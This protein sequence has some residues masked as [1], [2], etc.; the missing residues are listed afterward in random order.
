VRSG[1]K[2][3]WLRDP[4]VLVAA[5][6]VLLP[7]LTAA[8]SALRHPWIPTSDWA[9]IESEVRAV[10]T[11]D[12]PLVGAFSRFGW[13]H[14]GPLPFYALALPYRLVPSDRGLLFAAAVVNIVAVVAYIC[15]VA[16]QPRVR[17]LLALA[18]LAVL[19]RGI[20]VAD[21]GDPWNPTLPLI[22]FALYL[23]LCLEVATGERRWPLP[24]LVFV[25]AFCVQ[26]HLA[27]TY[28]VLFMGGAAFG[29]RIW[30]VL[31]DHYAE[32]GW[33]LFLRERWRAMALCLGVGLVAW[34]PP[35]LDQVNGDGNLGKLFAFSRG[36]DT[37]AGY[38]ATIDERLAIGWTPQYGAWLLE[39]FGLWM[40]EAEP[41]NSF[42]SQIL[43]PGD[44]PVLL[45]VPVALGIAL[46]VVWRGRLDP[47]DRRA[48]T[49]AVVV[50]A[51]GVLAV[52]AALPGLRGSPV[53]WA[54]RW[55]VV[56]VMA[57]WLALLWAVASVAP[58]FVPARSKEPGRERMVAVAGTAAL[59]GAIAY[60]VVRAV[61][62]GSTGGQPMHESSAALLEIRS[63][64]ER[65]GREDAPVV[66]FATF[67]YTPEGLA[68]PVLLDRAGIAWID[69]RD[70][71][72][73]GRARLEV[74][75]S[76][77]LER[78]GLAADL[79]AGRVDLVARSEKVDERGLQ[80][81][82]LRYPP[83]GGD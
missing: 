21:L 70:P 39:P 57:V 47:A 81:I 14:P 1:G 4:F 67:F 64:V 24:T 80:L 25:G 66:V 69:G 26:A 83:A 12:T 8:I 42:G 71:E 31:H 59:V 77:S 48:V 18:G 72:A 58:R 43:V 82:L 74:L 16:R 10:G 3:P 68:V 29:L 37:S 52:F 56:V 32:G 2:W 35:L 40:G 75:T 46:L 63:A 20:G 13:R 11:R 55:A 33:R 9:H 53:L 38:N 6:I 49:A 45:W 44:R 27:F 54:Y 79:A 51:A 22:P 30:H 41:M 78:P 60:P 36:E 76:D 61:W 15:V 5:A 28:P 62:Q 7:P 17:A 73:Q 23:V 19:M 34:A 50:A 65:S